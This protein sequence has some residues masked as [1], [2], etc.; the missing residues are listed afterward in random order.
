[1]A[2]TDLLILPSLAVPAV[3]IA[4]IVSASSVLWYATRRP[5]L[6]LLMVGGLLRT[7]EFSECEDL[8]LD[9][10]LDLG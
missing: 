6:A 1:M 3:A 9:L 4:W 8:C 10:R 5:H 2:N 7:Y